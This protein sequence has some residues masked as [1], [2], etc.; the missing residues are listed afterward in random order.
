MLVITPVLAFVKVLPANPNPR[1][2]DKVVCF[3]VWE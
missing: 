3:L 2:K 1:I